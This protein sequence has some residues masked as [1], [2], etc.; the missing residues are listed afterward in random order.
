MKNE[1]LTIY[2]AVQLM[3]LE[4]FGLAKLVPVD[5]M[6]PMRFSSSFS[7]DGATLEEM[8]AVPCEC[9]TNLREF[10]TIARTARLFEDQEYGQWGLEIIGPKQAAETTARCKIRRRRD[11]IEGDLVIGSFIGD[12]DLLLIRGDPAAKDFG[13]VLVALPLD[14]RIEWYKA[15]ESFG[16]FLDIYVKTGGDKFWTKQPNDVGKPE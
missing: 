10:W 8:A 12:S 5:G 2:E 7:M 6:P 15:A 16:A 1:P 11:Y 14:P 13:K 9:P 3:K 4:G